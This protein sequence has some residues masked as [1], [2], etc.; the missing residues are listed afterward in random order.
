MRDTGGEE[1]EQRFALTREEKRLRAALTS[2]IYPVIV[3]WDIFYLY[4]D[5][6][7]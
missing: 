6:P 2:S 5:L 3:L 1:W 4:L 7:S